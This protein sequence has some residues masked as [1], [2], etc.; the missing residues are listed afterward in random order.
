MLIFV[1]LRSEMSQSSLIFQ[2]LVETNINTMVTWLWLWC[3]F[4][5]MEI[6]GSGWLSRCSDYC[7][8]RNDQEVVVQYPAVVRDI[9]L[10]QGIHSAVG[11][12]LASSSVGTGGYM[13]LATQLRLVPKWIVP[14]LL[15]YSFMPC[16]TSFFSVNESLVLC[17]VS[18]VF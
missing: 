2:I 17:I 11:S 15:S 14:P 8:W 13:Q 7:Y 4:N 5:N 3:L 9:F 18:S 12:H 6:G 10:P 16:I 1:S